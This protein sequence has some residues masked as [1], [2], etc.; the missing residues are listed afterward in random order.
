MI[1]DTSALAA[2]VFQEPGYDTVLAR[3]ATSGACA[4]GTPTLV[5]AGILLS[6][7]LRSDARPL[8]ARLLQEL[9]IV[10]V[11]FGDEHWRAAVSA[12][13]L[14][15]KGRHAASLNFGDCLAYAVAKLSSEPLLCVGDDFAQ[16]DIVLA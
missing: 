4:V 15:G 16:T 9:D 14:Y 12:F 5:E 1:V 7:R 10:P 11:P 6:A 2:I 8:I 3:L 13:V